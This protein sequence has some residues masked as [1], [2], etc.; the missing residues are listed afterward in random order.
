MKRQAVLDY[1][2]IVIECAPTL[3]AREATVEKVCADTGAAF[4][5]P[6]N[7]IDVISGQGTI[8]L[9]LLQQVRCPPRHVV[10]GL[11]E[12]GYL[13]AACYL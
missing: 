1:G 2:G 9:E 4:L 10:T 13:A 12:A 7:D 6:S 8:A 3:A 5:H 11:V